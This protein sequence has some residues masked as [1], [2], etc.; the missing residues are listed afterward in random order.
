ML[1][2]LFTPSDAGSVLPPRAGGK[3]GVTPVPIVSGDDIGRNEP[4][5]SDTSRGPE[6]DPSP[7]ALQI[8]QDELAFVD[9]LAPLLGRSPR[10]L[11]RFV[12]TY[13]LMKASTSADERDVHTIM[14]VVALITNAPEV[15]AALVRAVHRLELAGGPRENLWASL[16]QLIDAGIEMEASPD[17]RQV[18]TWLSEK[19][20]L[21]TDLAQ[22]SEWC[23]RVVQY[24]FYVEPS[25]LRDTSYPSYA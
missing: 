18:R 23:R 14:F 8:A 19:H 3:G 6:I 16:S 13:R 20:G 22:L 4:E 12:N 1:H 17:W 7:D 21:T 15:A 10:A 9:E 24:S 25:W 5:R 11:K 2:Q